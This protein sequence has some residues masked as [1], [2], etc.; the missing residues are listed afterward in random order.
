MLKSKLYSSP[1]VHFDHVHMRRV[2]L[3]VTELENSVNDRSPS[4]AIYS[5]LARLPTVAIAHNRE[6]PVAIYLSE[7][8]ASL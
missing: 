3:E 7:C 1:S 5:Y 2:Q 6:D 4:H 8:N